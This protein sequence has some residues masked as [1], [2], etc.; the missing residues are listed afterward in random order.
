[1]GAEAIVEQVL[2]EATIEGWTKAEWCACPESLSSWGIEISGLIHHIGSSSIFDPS[3]YRQILC[4]VY[5]GFLMGKLLSK[6]L[7][8]IFAI[9]WSAHALTSRTPIPMET[10]CLPLFNQALIMFFPTQTDG[11]VSSN[12]RYGKLRCLQDSFQT[13]RKVIPGSPLSLKEKLV[14]TLQSTMAFHQPQ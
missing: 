11:K 13:H 4:P 14:C 9:F 7:R 8:T 3:L 1:M 5:L 6:S 10:L 2:E 12:L